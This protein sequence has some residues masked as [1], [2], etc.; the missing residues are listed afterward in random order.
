MS[1][2]NIVI[3]GAGYAGV[4][5]AKDLAKRY[6]KD[7]SVSITL[8]DRHSYHT[9]LTQLHEVAG[10]R[11]EPQ[12]IQMDLRKLFRKT[13]VRL[14]TD[15]VTQVDY[16]E[17]AVVTKRGKFP[18]D[19]LI[20]GMGAEPNDFGTPGVKEFGHTLGSWEDAVHLRHHIEHT[21]R[22]AAVVHDPAKRASM[23]TFIV[24]GSGFTGV[25][26][27]GELVEWKERLAKDN[28]LQPDEIK[29]MLVEA[30]DTILNMLERKD[31][32]K[33]EAYLQKKG[34]VILKESPIVE[35]K[36]DRIILKSADEI[37]THTLIW[38]AGVK[39]N[40]AT[41]DSG[42]SKA[43]AGRIKVDQYMESVDHKNVY[44][45]GDLAYYEEK[46]GQPT[47]QIVEAAEQTAGTAA[48][49]IIAE[50]S[51][52]EKRPFK[53]KYHGTMVSIGARYGV[54]H[55]GGMHLSG[56]FANFVKHMVNLLYFFLIGSGYYIFRYIKME[57]FRT[58]DKRNIFR[59][60]TSRYGNVLWSLPLRIFVGFFWIVEG[61]KK[62]F[63]ESVWNE[64]TASISSFSKLF[65]NGLGDDSW[66]VGS[67]VHMPFDWLQTTTSGASEAVAAGEWGTPIL[68]ESPGIFQWFMKI[69]LPTPEM[70]V[71][72]QKV[73]VFVEIAIGVA[74]LIG[75]FT[76]L[77]SALSAMFIAIFTLSAM[78][79]WD[80]FW[81]LPAAIALMNGAG[82]SL[83]L[84]YWVVPALQKRL[85]GKWY[86]QEQAIYSD[87]E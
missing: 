53:G 2:K 5:A 24:C 46:E 44:V 10:G 41:D 86:G 84:D 40:T 60:V 78:L 59:D 63:G 4:K 30:A 14:V 8:I 50:I 62:L 9:M 19:Y 57:L 71:L 82:R 51:G 49:A 65:K 77:A 29:L 72:M 58:R 69:M 54:A 42:L 22:Q 7:D 75:L 47:P 16:D 1:V 67:S 64:A 55:V 80:Q 43:K 27:I 79:G 26:M 31:A 66:L 70:A 3:V 45:V 32:N 73:M 35:V 15:E 12:G 13:K 56:W 6:K 36:S 39:A 28:K 21:V 34:V 81:A 52:G 33:A 25:E 38:T 48:Q 37:P 68:S 61:L 11:I 85:G 23:L 87:T 17:Q 83:G 76:W 20:L 18:Y 74:I